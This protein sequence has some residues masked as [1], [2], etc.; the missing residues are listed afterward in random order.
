MWRSSRSRTLHPFVLARAAPGDIFRRLPFRQVGKLGRLLTLVEELVHRHSQS[1][2]HL[3]ERIDGGNGGPVLNPRDVA[4]QQSRA[5]LDVSLRE[6][7]CFP[8][9]LQSVANDNRNNTTRAA[10]LVTGHD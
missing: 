3:F 10:Y 4:T 5:L 6:M 2:R 1:A 7:L 9:N 8:K